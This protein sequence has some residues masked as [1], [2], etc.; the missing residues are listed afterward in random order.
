M[1]QVFEACF[2]TFAEQHP[3]YPRRGVAILGHHYGK[4]DILYMGVNPGKD[5]ALD[6]PLP[7]T[8]PP[9]IDQQT[10]PEKDSHYWQK[11]H[12]MIHEL[13]R[14]LGA[15]S[16]YT[17]VYSNTIPLS[18]P[19]SSAIKAAM[20]PPFAPLFDRILRDVQPKVL[21]LCGLDTP[22]FIHYFVKQRADA[23]HMSFER[24]NQGKIIWQ[25]L[26]DIP[27]FSITHFSVPQ[28]REVFKTDMQHLEKFLEAHL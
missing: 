16:D 14:Y 4:A 10:Q 28:R 23:H 25:G 19:R 22:K 12:R 13:P 18:T 26:P 17:A 2:A 27:W 21:I 11:A 7:H 15:E 8:K 1:E 20:K 24:K 6:P 9:Y 3:D 5:R